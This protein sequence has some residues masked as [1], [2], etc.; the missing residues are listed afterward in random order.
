VTRGR[1]PIHARPDDGRRVFVRYP[2]RRLYDTKR[3]R[4]VPFDALSRLKAGS[5]VVV[6]G[7]TGQDIT[8][9]CVNAARHE[10]EGELLRA[11]WRR[12]EQGS[13]NK[14]GAGP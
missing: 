14:E 8:S 6:Y 2:N 9:W 11:T 3:A 4:Y 10:R 1:P 13:K 7:P 5:F 12:I